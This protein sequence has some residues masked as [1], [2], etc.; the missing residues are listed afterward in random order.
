MNK[1][2]KTILF[3]ITFVLILN[4]SS[5][6]LT[7]FNYKNT[8][9]LITGVLNWNDKS[10]ASFSSEERKDQELYELFK[11]KGVSPQNA[12]LLLDNKATL[13]N[14]K[15]SLIKIAEA[16]SKNSNLI[17]YYAGHGTMLEGGDVYFANYDIDSKNMPKTG[18]NTA[19]IG[20]II[21]KYFKGNLVILM[22]DCCYSG[23]LCKEAE[24]LTK[25]GVNTI[26]VTSASSSNSSTA[27]WTFTQSIIDGISGSSL[28][29]H[30]FDKIIALSEIKDEVFNSMKY[31]EHQRSGNYI[32]FNL[33]D[34]KFSNKQDENYVYKKIAG[35]FKAGDYVFGN[36][37]N[38]WQCA[39]ILDYKKGWYLVE[40]YFYTDKKD[41][42]LPPDKI[43]Q[44]I[45][46]NLPAGKN[47]TVQWGG[48]NWNAKI[49][50][51]ENGF[52][53]ITYPDWPSFWDEWIAYDRVVLDKS[54]ELK[55]EKAD[56]LWEGNWYPA[57]ILL[58]NNG[59]YFVHYIDY[60]YTWDEWVA[61][62]RIKAEKGFFKKI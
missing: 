2:K 22:A 8:Y 24:Y 38:K 5:F 44:E 13:S 41:I 18:L 50:K 17:F 52:H 23:S 46:V 25:S 62:K 61:S 12:V 54:P 51:E 14:I 19:D 60:N 49:I 26:A 28:F 31:R 33:D 3:L 39:R 55:F 10:F 16:S 37:L 58:K 35:D 20:K 32:P 27:N 47:I 4:Y 57:V 59:K 42:E 1:M 21:K 30:N 11:S 48:K 56:V 9:I 36:Y 45:F 7:D 34:I 53:L 29:D 43:K 6:A 15:N 40:F